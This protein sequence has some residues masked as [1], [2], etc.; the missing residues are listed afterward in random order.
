MVAGCTYE[1]FVVITLFVRISTRRVTL[2]IQAE[3]H[4]SL[5]VNFLLF[6]SYFNINCDTSLLR[7]VRWCSFAFKLMQAE[8]L[9][10]G[11]GKTKTRTI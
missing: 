9:K 6:S 10:C 2:K 5:G 3:G 7:F 1:K 11:H 8:M 4:V